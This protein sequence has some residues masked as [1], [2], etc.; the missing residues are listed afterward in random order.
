[1]AATTSAM[2]LQRV[3]ECSNEHCEVGPAVLQ[4]AGAVGAVRHDV[5]AVEHA[6]EGLAEKLDRLQMWM[7]ATLASALIGGV[8]SVVNY[9]MNH[10]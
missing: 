6:V 4:L 2:A 1:M 9:L 3:P 10:R 8:V 5:D 7:M